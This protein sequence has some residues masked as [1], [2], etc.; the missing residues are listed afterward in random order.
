[1]ETKPI[2]TIGRKVL[3]LGMHDA[4]KSGELI[5]GIPT[6]I[7]FV[8]NTTERDALE[9]LAPGTFVATYGLEHVYQLNGSGSWATIR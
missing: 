9:G 1:M 7:S 8:A 4:V 2:D 6:R 3:E 5:T